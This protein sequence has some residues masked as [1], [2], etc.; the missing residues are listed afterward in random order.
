M[1][2]T[3]TQLNTEIGQHIAQLDKLELEAEKHRQEVKALLAERNEME[4]RLGLDQFNPRRVSVSRGRATVGS[5]R[6]ASRSDATAVREWGKSQ[7]MQVP[8]K[9]PIP[10]AVREAY[11]NAHPD[12]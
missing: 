9:G 5:R 8:D 10:K 3:Y 6:T 4:S 2:K 1:E 11:V 12:A 7:G